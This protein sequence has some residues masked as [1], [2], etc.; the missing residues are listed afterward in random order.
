[1]PRKCLSG[2]PLLSTGSASNLNKCSPELALDNEKGPRL[3]SLFKLGMKSLH[4]TANDEIVAKLHDKLLLKVFQ[5]NIAGD[6][7]DYTDSKWKKMLTNESS[8]VSFCTALKCASKKHDE[9][10]T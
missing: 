3:K 10:K 4:E 2:C 7:E 8:N 6:V 5:A 1:L 9:N